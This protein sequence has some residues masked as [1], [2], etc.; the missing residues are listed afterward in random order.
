MP[1]SGSFPAV[2]MTTT[3]MMMTTTIMTT[4]KTGHAHVEVVLQ[5][6]KFL[7]GASQTLRGNTM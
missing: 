4:T 7:F 1:M 5:G 6:R 2:I 3:M